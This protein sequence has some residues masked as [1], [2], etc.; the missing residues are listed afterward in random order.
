MT[1]PYCGKNIEDDSI[2][3]IFCEHLLSPVNAAPSPSEAQSASPDVQSSPSVSAYA[4]APYA[5]IPAPVKTRPVYAA[6][7]SGANTEAEEEDDE[8]E[9]SDEP[10]TTGQFL[11]TLIVS[12]IP[13][14]GII[15]LLIWVCSSSQNENKRNLSGALLILKLVGLFFVLG[16]CLAYFFLQFPFFY[17]W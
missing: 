7:Y 6:P 1:C 4:A 14:I 5:P 8:D 13:I 3:C 16:A 11:G 10:L 17:M 15:F 12:L 2:V 9:D